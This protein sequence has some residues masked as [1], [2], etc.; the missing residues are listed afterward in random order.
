MMSGR[1]KRTG[2]RWRQL[3]VLA[4]AAMLLQGCAYYVFNLGDFKDNP[5]DQAIATGNQDDHMKETRER[6]LKR[7][8]IGRPVATVREYLQSVGAKC[9]NGQNTGAPVTCR[10]SKYA[11]D[12]LRT[13]L[14]DILEIRDTHNF[15]IELIHRRGLLRE[16]RVCRQITREWFDGVIP[17]RTERTEY[18][19]ECLNGQ[20]TKGE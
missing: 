17:E 10:Y 13:P 5:M 16:V 2:T 3:L 4:G 8:P 11:D 9:R 18:P 12:V 1:E 14:G 7:Y 6:L 20:N 15:R 19:M